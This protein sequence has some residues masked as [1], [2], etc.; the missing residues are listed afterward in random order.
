MHPLID[1][2]TLEKLTD[3]ELLRL[4]AA[5]RDL[6]LSRDLSEA[7]LRRCLASLSNAVFVCLTR[8]GGRLEIGLP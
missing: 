6:I 4:E 5:L 3:A 1:I 2:T 7:D 8:N